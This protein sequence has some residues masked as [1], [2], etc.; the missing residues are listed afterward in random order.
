MTAAR[1]TQEERLLHYLYEHP[2][3]SS[4]EIV[5]DLQIINTTGRISDLRA[6]G[7]RIHASRDRSG[8]FRFHLEAQPVQIA[9]GL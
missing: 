8:V 1:R 3:C 4:L 9:A 7:Y 6:K 5:R 2:G